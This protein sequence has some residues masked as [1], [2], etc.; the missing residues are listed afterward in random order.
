VP[1][2]QSLVTL[3][4]R[5][6]VEGVTTAFRLGTAVADR[7]VS[8]V[9]PGGADSGAF[10]DEA[11]G[12]VQNEAAPQAPPAPEAPPPAPTD[13]R[14]EPP[15]PPPAEEPEPAVVSEEPVLVAESADPGA[16]DGAG[17]EIDV[18][19]PWPGY[20]SA[21]AD[22]IVARI[23]EASAAEVAVVQL[24]ENLHRRRRSVLQAAERRL[25]TLNDPARRAP[26][27]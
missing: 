5:I 25:K 26:G 24:H 18:A 23:S 7:V 14:P 8:L 1:S 3:P 13:A 9:I 15:P 27:Q 6:A 2:P 17:P 20:R 16:A 12:P 22:E 19:E 10:T 11:V 4:L 21:R